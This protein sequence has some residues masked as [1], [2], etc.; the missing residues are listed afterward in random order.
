MAKLEISD[1]IEIEEL[2]ARYCHRVDHGDAEGWAA[3]FTPD[4]SFEVPGALRARGAAGWTGDACACRAGNTA[5]TC[6]TRSAGG[7]DDREHERAAVFTLSVDR[8]SGGSVGSVLVARPCK[9]RPRLPRLGQPISACARAVHSV[10]GTPCTP[11][12]WR[13]AAAMS[14]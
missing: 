7:S 6:R 8:L 1:R 5:R 11:T 2:L 14:C 13:I 9:A 3:L 4:A 12:V 10:V